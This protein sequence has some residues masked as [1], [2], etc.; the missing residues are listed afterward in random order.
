MIKKIFGWLGLLVLLFIG[1]VGGFILYN[2]ITKE[3][4]EPSKQMIVNYEVKEIWQGEFVGKFLV[5]RMA[6]L[7]LD[8][9]DYGLIEVASSK[10][11]NYK[12]RVTVLVPSDYLPSS[13]WFEPGK[14][15]YFWILPVT[16]EGMVNQ[17]TK[18][19]YSPVGIFIPP[20]LAEQKLRTGEW[21]LANK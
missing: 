20:L 14:T 13:V 18:L 8:H 12:F 4:P 11:N 9:R 1:V 15:I 19:L 17:S 5:Y 3:Q 16:S 2:Q 10:Q 21:T 7:G 6:G